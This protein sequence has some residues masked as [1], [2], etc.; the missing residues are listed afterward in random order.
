MAAWNE[1]LTGGGEVMLADDPRTFSDGGCA[2]GVAERED[3]RLP[4]SVFEARRV[5][6]SRRRSVVEVVAGEQRASCAVS[7]L[8][9]GVL[10]SELLLSRCCCW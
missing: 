5:P 9:G 7:V 6:Q 4:P 3:A 8:R 1:K 10:V 2:G